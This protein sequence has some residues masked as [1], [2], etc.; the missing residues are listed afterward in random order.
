MTIPVAA[1]KQRL[2]DDCLKRESLGFRILTAGYQEA[3]TQIKDPIG[4]VTF[5]RTAVAA[6][7]LFITAVFFMAAVQRRKDLVFVL[8]LLASLVGTAATA[9][10]ASYYLN[11]KIAVSSCQDKLFNRTMDRV[12]ES[13][14]KNFASE[15][16]AEPLVLND[17]SWNISIRAKGRVLSWSY[18]QKKALNEGELNAFM[19]QQQKE[20]PRGTLF[21]T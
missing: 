6:A 20:F 9:F 7:Y 18:R 1:V 3:F 12:A 16:Q 15:L 17:P 2:L 11:R 4:R 10:S 5:L 14:L 13:A 8:V 21:E 19:N